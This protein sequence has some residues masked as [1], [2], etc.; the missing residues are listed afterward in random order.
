MPAGA[1]VSESRADADEEARD[2]EHP[3]C[4][5]DFDG[6]ALGG[7]QHAA[8]PREDE[9]SHEGETPPDVTRLWGEEPTDNAADAGHAAFKQ[10]HRRGGGTDQRAADGGEPGSELRRHD[11]PQICW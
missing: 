2:D 1:A 7:E 11:S 5:L 3:R 9:P 10:E 4:A 6:D 8:D